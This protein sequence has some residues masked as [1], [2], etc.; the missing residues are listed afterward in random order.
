MVHI[1]F[2]S[3][4]SL[5]Q[6]ERHKERGIVGIT[7][8]GDRLCL[9]CALFLQHYRS[10]CGIY[11][12]DHEIQ[13]TIAM[14]AA[15]L[16]IFYA[17]CTCRSEFEC[18]LHLRDVGTLIRK[19]VQC[20]RRSQNITQHRRAQDRG[21]NVQR[22][23]PL[24]QRQFDSLGLSFWHPEALKMSWKGCSSALHCHILEGRGKMSQSL[25]GIWFAGR[26]GRL[27]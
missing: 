14:P 2:S 12:C 25:C 21:E 22:G 16:S 19:H 10:E 1:A 5:L 26:P 6:R 20:V 7:S 9:S 24:C 23:T 15:L 17:R 3:K 18:L 11:W 27:G 8:C 4:K 13:L